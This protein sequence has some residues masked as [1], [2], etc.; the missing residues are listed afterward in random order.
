MSTKFPLACGRLR[1]IISLF[2]GLRRF[3]RLH[4]L[5]ILSPRFKYIAVMPNQLRA[6]DENLRF[7]DDILNKVSRSFAAV[8][9]QVC[10][11]VCP[12]SYKYKSFDLSINSISPM[13]VV[14]SW[15]VCG[16]DDILPGLESIGYHRR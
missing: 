9:R 3:Q 2:H 1:T 14:T 7:C 6:G 11:S 10:L 4:V 5:S 15:S 8:I 12:M 13:S 16:C